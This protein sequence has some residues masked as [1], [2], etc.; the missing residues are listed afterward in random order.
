MVLLTACDGEES[1]LVPCSW[2]STSNWPRLSKYAFP[3]RKG[4]FHPGRIS[5]SPSC[6]AC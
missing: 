1:S 4:P 5:T 3:S 6:A 2:P